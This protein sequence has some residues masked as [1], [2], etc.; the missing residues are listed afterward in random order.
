MGIGL[1]IRRWMEHEGLKI[2]M[3]CFT[4]SRGAA[5]SPML[6]A[7]ALGRIH[8]SLIDLFD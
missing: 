8:S 1:A 3:I 4:R 2:E 6:G 7:I 5:L